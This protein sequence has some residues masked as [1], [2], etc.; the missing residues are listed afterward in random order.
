MAG[1]DNIKDKGFD[2]RTTE[3]LREITSKGGRASGEARRKAAGFRKALRTILA[4]SVDNPEW[5]AT[6]N[7]L[8]LENTLENAVNIAMVKEATN[9]NVK[10]YEAIA[11]YSGQ[12]AQTELDDEEQ[13]IRADRARQAR[14][15]EVGNTDS[16]EENIQS[17]L[18]AMSPGEEEIER[19]FEEGEEDGEETEEASEL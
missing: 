1:Y 18:R 8:G 10:A 6:F 14:D 9:G 16:A 12:S 17:F 3:E 11:K 2:H 7:M 13:Q 5:E 15:Q 19:L 4:C